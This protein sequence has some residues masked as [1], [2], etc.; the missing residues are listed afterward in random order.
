MDAP[1]LGKLLSNLTNLERLVDNLKDGIIGHDLKRNI[2][3]F[4]QQAEKI[5][6]YD[7]K[8]VLGKDCHE[9]FSA[10]F[11]GNRC[12]FCSEMPTLN[13]TAEYSI[14]IVTK[15]GET[16]D[17]EM[18]ATMMQDE[19]GHDCGV[20]AAFKDVTELLDLR[21]RIG[22]TSGFANI[23]GKDSKM[24]E[25]FQ[26]IRDVADYDFPVHISG[27]TGTGKELVANAIHTESRRDGGPFVP[28]NC[29]ALPEG[30]I[31]SELFGHV[32]GAFSGAIR[33]KKGRFELAHNGTI[34]LD[35]VADLPFAL[36][37]KFL[38]F[39]EEGI[40]VKVGGEKNISVDVRIISATNKD[41]QK[42]V[43][44]HRFREDL[45]Y[46]L[47][48]IPIHIPPIR[49]RKNDI[50][51]LVD[52][53]LSLL[54]QPKSG[55]KNNHPSVRI[56]DLALSLMM[57]YRWPGNVR[58]LQNAIHYAI[59][60]CHGS[61]IR[62]DDLPLEFKKFIGGSVKRGSSKKL[63][64]DSVKEAMVKSGGNKAKAARALKVGRS[65]L[66]RFLDEYP[67][68]FPDSE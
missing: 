14:K 47:N 23:I 13:D 41:L 32:K 43:K 25:I 27:E 35:E 7:R 61:M 40:F 9:A 51:L 37:V 44:R 50:P 16:R 12:S 18:S 57:D 52:H 22:E 54:N 15:S 34:F 29:G 46:R 2:F 60:K 20:L 59:V 21:L 10:P 6:G 45:Y 24:M 39:I 66:Y 5:T 65:T 58:E 38:R 28:I 63:N 17:I 1:S 68:I 55:V 49:Q 36:Q 62:A 30:L 67:D 11:C 3:Y 26:Q 19:N 64:L 56:S 8:E 31:E 42:E 4:N 33:D 53:C 48:V